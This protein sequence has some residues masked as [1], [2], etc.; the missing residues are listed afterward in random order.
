MNVVL[1]PLDACWLLKVHPPWNLRGFLA[2][3]ENDGRIPLHDGGG[4]PCHFYV[5]SLL[6]VSEG[7]VEAM[8]PPCRISA[9]TT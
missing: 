6:E 2:R 7:S 5:L 9:F 3:E 1:D 4:L 8:R